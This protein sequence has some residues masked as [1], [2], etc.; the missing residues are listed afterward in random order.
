MERRKN[1]W[2]HTDLEVRQ[3]RWFGPSTR[4]G[5]SRTQVAVRAAG[6]SHGEDL[7]WIAVDR[8][9]SYTCA[10]HSQ[11]CP[12]SATFSAQVW[13]EGLRAQHPIFLAPCFYFAGVEREAWV[14]RGRIFP[15]QGVEFLR[16]PCSRH[17]LL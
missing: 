14:S 4:H 17:C 12:Q 8:L 15:N 7:N 11:I 5:E 1:K 2:T 13:R 6:G 16:F 10:G 3:P 9:T